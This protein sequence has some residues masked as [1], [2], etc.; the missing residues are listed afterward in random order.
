MHAKISSQLQFPAL[1]TALKQVQLRYR[2]KWHDAKATTVMVVF[3]SVWL[4][5]SGPLVVLSVIRSDD[6]QPWAEYCRDSLGALTASVD[7]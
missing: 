6:M 7:I 3:L 1:A 2:T 4:I 5:D